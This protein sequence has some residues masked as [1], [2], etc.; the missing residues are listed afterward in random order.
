MAETLASAEQIDA[1]Q[2]PRPIQKA[3]AEWAERVGNLPPARL[4]SGG[5]HGDTGQEILPLYTSADVEIDEMRDLGVPGQAPF[6]RGAY[7]KGYVTRPWLMVQY[8]GFATVEET[9]ERWKSLIAAGQRAV[10][11]AFD[12]P[13]HLGYDSDHVLSE[14]EVGKAGVAIDS[15]TDFEI[16]FDGIDLQRIPA[17][18]N[19]A[20]VAPVVVAM[21]Q[22]LGEKRGV[23]AAELKGTITNDS[24][25]AAFRGTCVFPAE[26][27]VKVVVDVIE[28]CAEQMPK[29]TPINVQG[30]YMRSVGATKAQE[31]GYAMAFALAYLSEAVSR[32]LEIERIAPRFSF[33]FQCDSHIFEEAAKFRA[34]RRVWSELIEQ[35]FGTTDHDSRLLRVTGVS[36][37]RCFTKEEPEANLVRGA[38][39][40]LGCALGGV[41]GMWISGYDEAF[42]TP[43]EKASTL[44]LRTMQILAEETGV[45]AT[46]D[47]LGGGYFPEH[48][49]TLMAD[50]MHR[51]VREVDAMGGSIEASASGYLRST[52]LENDLRWA[53]EREHGER[54]IVGHN[55]YRAARETDHEIEFQRF[56][57]EVRDDQVRRLAAVRARRDQSAVQ[58]KLAAVRLAAANGENIM[59][60][61]VDAV[62]EYAT[63]GEIMDQLRSVFGEW[64]E[65][66]I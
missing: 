31:A 22:V 30:V 15:L 12:L 9:N 33:F 11:L 45:R 49:T 52:M 4:G 37:A 54:A 24:L 58:E 38:Y 5:D 2:P 17:T 61:I 13:S 28:Y 3:R 62:R 42:A 7:P 8:A 66:A 21:Y 29:F 20:A 51:H 48:L 55:I 56:R 34:A 39:S 44:A 64:E 63:V 47:P 18:F 40:A 6:V 10:S 35:R 25:S 36:A 19:T 60:S 27:A 41:Q 53:Y 59:P 32:G 26:P 1:C 50:Q 14:D 23:P 46:I 43:T 65:T 16:L 57:P